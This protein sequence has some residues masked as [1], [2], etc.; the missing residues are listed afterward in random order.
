MLAHLAYI[1]S[2]VTAMRGD[3]DRAIEFCIEAREHVPAGNLALEFDS[4]VT[5]GYEYF[6][7]GDYANA[8][9]ILN[10]AIRSG[11]GAG[12]VIH[13][14]AAS[15]MM[16][17]VYANQGLLNRAYDTYRKAAKRIPEAGEQH[18]DARALIEMGL[19]DILCEW[20]DLDAAL[21]HIEQALA[22]L[23][24]WGKA[25]DSILAYATLARILLALGNTTGAAEAVEEAVQATQA[26]GVFSEAR[27]AVEIAQVRLWLAQD[28]LLPAERWAASQ[29]ACFRAG[30]PF[31]FEDE[32]AHIMRARV[33]IALNKPDDAIAI[34]SRLED[35]ARSAGRMGRLLEIL[36][37]QALAMQATGNADQARL[38]LTACLELAEPEGYARVFL[39]E[40]QPMRQL[41]GQWLA[42]AS[43]GSLQDYAM[44]LLAQ[45]DAEPHSAPA[46]SEE[47][48]L[49]GGPSV[50]VGQVLIE[51]LTPRE[52]EVL[53]LIALGRTNKEIARELIV[54][55]GTIKAH[56][57]SIYRKLDVAN[58]T[59]AVARARELG[60][61]P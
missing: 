58:R 10:A 40:G 28:D 46:P 15:C 4:R 21:A 38:A 50:S 43:A 56:S 30:D 16:A 11:I 18:L 45:F 55:P 51:P 2:R 8:S 27:C 39:D 42:Q 17:R 52:L 5:L 26:N 54:A 20:N 61:L 1:K 37:L 32:M 13:T 59:E 25:D 22:L 6:L 49:V 41:L 33:H 48:H 29:A 36:L 9:R 47:A 7:S 19:A 35:T 31:R 34:L 44:R 3:I 24:W 12:A 57:S 53:H 60:I 23:P 14:V